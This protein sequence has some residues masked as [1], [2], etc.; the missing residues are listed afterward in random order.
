MAKDD[1]FVIVYQILS[2][3]YKCLKKGEEV[4][5]TYLSYGSPLYPKLNKRYWGYIMENLEKD[6]YISGI[7]IQYF[8]NEL[9]IYALDNCQITPKGIAYLTDNSLFSKAKEAAETLGEII[10]PLIK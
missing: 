10:V 4:D 6:G 2:Y 7:A 5:S 3:L 9:K 8:D 1:Y